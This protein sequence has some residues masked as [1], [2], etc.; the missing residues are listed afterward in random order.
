M[1]H[2]IRKQE[3]KRASQYACIEYINSLMEGASA[4]EGRPVDYNNYGNHQ[5]FD[6]RG[7]A[8]RPYNTYEDGLMWYRSTQPQLDDWVI[9]Q[10]AY[11]NLKRTEHPDLE[12]AVVKS[13]EYA[14]L[15]DEGIRLKKRRDKLQARLEQRKRSK[16]G[17][18]VNKAPP[19]N[20]FILDFDGDSKSEID[21]L[22]D[23][24][25]LN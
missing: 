10:I 9:S 13:N 11:E 22:Y 21:M 12:R 1:T 17:V 20:P 8:L 7:Q 5:S 14:G 18:K 25:E 24:I 6:I 2:Y 3:M 19:D 16:E 23:M 15:T 4:C